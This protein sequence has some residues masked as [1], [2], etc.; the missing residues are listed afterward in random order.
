MGQ[1]EGEND[2]SGGLS[3]SAAVKVSI[4]FSKSG[5]PRESGP[6]SLTLFPQRRKSCIALAPVFVQYPRMLARVLSAAVNGI[7][8]FPVGVEVYSG[9]GIRLW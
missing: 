3:K 6:W 4:L 7:E 5:L 2:C 9:W 8:A 1:R